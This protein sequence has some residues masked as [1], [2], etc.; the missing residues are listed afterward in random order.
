MKNVLILGVAILLFAFTEIAS[1]F[2]SG[3]AGCSGDCGA[4]HSISTK[5]VQ[6]LVSSVGKQ[7]EVVE[8]KP[9]PVRGLYQ[10]TVRQGK[11]EG[12]VYVDFG[13]R[14]LISG[15]IIDAGQRKDVTQEELQRRQRIDV[16]KINTEH[17]LLLGNP[18][19]TKKLYV[20]T[21]PECPYCAQLHAELD[22]LVRD[23][24]QLLV[25]IILFPLDIHPD[26][27]WKTDSITCTAKTD[28]PGALA[29]LERSFRKEPVERITCSASVADAALLRAGELGIG[30]AP[31]II[32]ADGRLLVG[33]RKKE[34]LQ[35]MLEPEQTKVG[36]LR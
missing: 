21:D 28:M 15:R 6:S 10:A 7:M 19:G 1:G 9:A 33:V 29:M 23:E 22:Q 18:A 31:T 12:I 2:G 35:K 16:T 3:A 14:Y 36:V 34:E 13:K 32:T 26:A 27:R 11:E 30:V 8:V 17:A 4:C 24:P 20:F 5:E 25:Y